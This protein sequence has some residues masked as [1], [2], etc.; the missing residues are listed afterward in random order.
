MDLLLKATATNQ[1]IEVVLV[2][3]GAP[4]TFSV[5]WPEVAI[6]QY[7]AW[8]RRYL[9]HNDPAAAEVTADAVTIRGHALVTSL[10]TWFADPAW[11]PLDQQRQLQKA[12]TPL[13]ISFEG[14][15]S[16]LQALPWEWLPWDQPIWRTEQQQ[17]LIQKRQRSPHQPQLLVWIG[18]EKG[19]SLTKELKQLEQLEKGGHI[20]LHI[21]R[22][23]NAGLADLKTALEQQGPWDALIFLG[24]SEADP[25]GGG[26]LQ[27]ADGSW[28]AAPELQRSIE[29]AV[30][31]GLELV[32][33][34]SCSGMDLARSL[35]RF[36]VGWA[37]CFREPVT[38]QAASAAFQRLLIELTTS[39]PL[40][41][42]T[43]AVRQWLSRHGPAGS[44]LLLTLIGSASATPYELPLSKK[45]Q[46]LLRISTTN[47]KQWIFAG[48][49]A[50]LG[51]AV[52]VLPNNPVSRYGLDRRL[53]VQRLWRQ[54]TNQP[55]PSSPALPVLVIDQTS[56]ERLGAVT[57]PNRVSRQTLAM[58]LSASPPED[59][60]KVALDVVLDETAPHTEALAEV[61][62]KQKRSMVFAGYF[63]DTVEAPGAGAISEP[64]QQLKTAGLRW[65]NLSTGMVASD[66]KQ[67]P[68]PLLLTEPITSANFAAQLSRYPERVV[69]ADA[70]I[71]WSLNWGSLI[72]RIEIEQLPSLKSPILL[73]GTDGTTNAEHNDLFTTPGA[74]KPEFSTLWKGSRT[75]MPGVIVQAVLAQSIN[76]KHW[77]KPFSSALATTLSA[78]L[79]IAMSALMA[80]RSRRLLL[81]GSIGAAAIP[82][83]LQLAISSLW[84]IPI[85]LPLGTLL[86]LSWI[87]ED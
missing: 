64:H 16:E 38:C 37:V 57:Q 41:T 53:Y 82:I 23:F 4:S 33:L 63:G 45:R 65:F 8:C 87:R 9:A 75:K 74:L 34:N 68:V 46:F 49:L 51:C 56:A 59:V 85:L 62:S 12:P 79:G 80:S 83:C 1:P 25:S 28:I 39:K 17:L 58:L 81:C 47:R 73:I 30:E 69:P 26:R 14:V 42:A 77:F 15:S 48:A 20:K 18:L 19:L 78:G 21:R 29:S 22:G 5:P 7:K 84:L 40:T 44:S 11:R 31:Q 60:P 6:Q 61:I 66:H 36:G 24:H 76:L 52:D 10:Q 71:D 27:L 13:R 35:V 32:L 86:V 54:A 72:E 55:G 50:L 3:A 43:H 2:G 70:V 67:Q